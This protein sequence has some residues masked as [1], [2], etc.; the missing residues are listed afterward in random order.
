[1]VAFLTLSLL[2]TQLIRNKSITTDGFQW[3]KFSCICFIHYRQLRSLCSCMSSVISYDHTG[4]LN[5]WIVLYPYIICLRHLSFSPSFSLILYIVI[6]LNTYFIHQ[7]ISD[8]RS[9]IFIWMKSINVYDHWFISNY[10]F[11]RCI[12]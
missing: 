4:G 6:A 5:K 2:D 1:M 10:L 8:S 3:R 9:D 7:K 11:I 12:A